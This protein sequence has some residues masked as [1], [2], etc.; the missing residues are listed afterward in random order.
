ML[1]SVNGLS[2]SFGDNLL[3]ENIGFEIESDDI[4]GL[5]GGNGC[6]KTASDNFHRPLYIRQTGTVLLD[7][8]RH[9]FYLTTPT[10]PVP[11]RRNRKPGENML[12]KIVSAL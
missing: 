7:R 1:L 4:V 12:L 3:F 2:K 8:L 10:S 11:L 6:G 9:V 5:I